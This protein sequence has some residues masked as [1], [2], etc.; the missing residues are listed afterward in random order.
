MSAAKSRFSWALSHG[1]KETLQPF[2]LV[3]QWCYVTTDV[4][5]ERLL[6]KEN[7]KLK[8]ILQTRWTTPRCER[9]SP[10]LMHAS[11]TVQK[12]KMQF[13]FESTNAQSLCERPRELAVFITID[14]AV[15]DNPLR[16]DPVLRHEEAV[17][18]LARQIMLW[19]KMNNDGTRCG[20]GIS[21]NT[22][23]S[24]VAS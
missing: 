19:N 4:L 16:L 7:E 12:K 5:K 8:F 20:Q 3:P 22:T 24:C 18:K 13:C 6:S 21:H 11:D 15:Q 1:Y 2:L 9:P 14:I 17:H 23:F 10:V